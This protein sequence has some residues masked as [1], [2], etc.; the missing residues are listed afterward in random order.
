MDRKLHGS[1]PLKHENDPYEEF[2]PSSSF[3]SNLDCKTDVKGTI[4]KK[5]YSNLVEELQL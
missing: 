2:K 3:N 5:E 4:P 1:S